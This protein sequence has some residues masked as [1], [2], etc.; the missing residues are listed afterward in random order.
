MFYYFKKS[1]QIFA[2][3]LVGSAFATESH[4][5]ASL[6]ISSER[7]GVARKAIEQELRNNLILR[8]AV[9][10]AGL[11]MGAYMMYSYWYDTNE[12]VLK[13]SEYPKTMSWKW[14]KR[15]SQMT[16]DGVIV[17]AATQGVLSAEWLKSLFHQKTLEWFV[18]T[19][20]H[21]FQ[22]LEE[23]KA[24]VRVLDAQQGYSNSQIEYARELFI[25]TNE[26]V[27]KQVEA[28]IA[29]LEYQS[30]TIQ[31]HA[32]S[33]EAFNAVITRIHTMTNDFLRNI[34]EGNAIVGYV[35][36]FAR[37]LNALLKRAAHVEQDNAWL[38]DVN[39]EDRSRIVH[40]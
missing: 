27:L 36:D 18:Q 38:G 19:H 1:C 6:R 4:S 17:G 16:R 21:I 33:G 2:I 23:L 22:S 29:F 37:E 20:T 34:H 13:L 28:I 26:S 24:A 15:L 39:Q 31:L 7:V 14:F 40:G 32:P 30:Q 25:F 12:G 9:V 35:D 3:V 5:H 11:S 10:T 8:G